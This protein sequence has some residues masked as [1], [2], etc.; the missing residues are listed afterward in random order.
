MTEPDSRR[1]DERFPVEG[2]FAKVHC[3][4]FEV[5]GA[6]ARVKPAG[7]LGAIAGYPRKERQVVN[8]S[9]GGLAFE[10]EEPFKKGQK[11]KVL[12]HAPG[13]EEPIELIAAVRWQKGLVGG[14][15]LTVGVQF[16]AF[17]ERKGLNPL[18]ALEALRGLEAEH[19]RGRPPSKG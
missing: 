7:V 17:G 11:L 19:A 2:A 8:L 15:V 16:D 12:L 13:L 9:K 14:Y 3:A 10:S 1:Q 6:S 4:P 5:A 18:A